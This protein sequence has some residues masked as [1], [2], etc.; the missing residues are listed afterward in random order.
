MIYFLHN[1]II[2]ATIYFISHNIIFI[3]FIV[4]DNIQKS[5][6]YLYIFIYVYIN[7]FRSKLTIRNE[8]YNLN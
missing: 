8:A 6:V 7:S 1:K 5:Y 4:L 3:I 2:Y